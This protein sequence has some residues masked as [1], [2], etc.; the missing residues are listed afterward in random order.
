MGM[1]QRP[2]DIPAI[3]LANSTHFFIFDLNLPQD[4][5]K[6]A[7]AT[8]RPEF[9]TKPNGYH[10]WYYKNGL[11]RPVRAKLTLHKE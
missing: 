3:I 8:G 9:M 5:E 10:F 7:K 1:H 2:V 11:N 6:I 4:R